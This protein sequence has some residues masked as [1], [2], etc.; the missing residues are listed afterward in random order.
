MSF[1]AGKLAVV[2]GANSGIGFQ[3]VRELAGEASEVIMICR[4]RERGEQA[5][6]QILKEYP[7]AVLTLLIA[8]LSSP[9]SIS[10]LMQEMRKRYDRISLLVNNAGGIFYNRLT[11]EDGLEYTFALNHMGYFRTTAALLP[12]LE[13]GRPSRVINV[14]SEAHR[15]TPL[16]FDDL[17]QEKHY[18]PFIA[19]GQSKLANILYTREL[20]RRYAKQGITAAALHPGFI[21]SGFGADAGSRIGAR[22]FSVTS[23]LFGSPPSRGAASVLCL[24]RGKSLSSGSYYAKCFIRKPSRAALDREAAERLWDLSTSLCGIT[25]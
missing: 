24:A 16:D 6:E 13:K 17:Q 21:N 20:A 9:S 12:L 11:A 3:T 4:S 1:I 7:Q 5:R 25:S 15:V 10:V 23:Q 18:R 19:Y 14:S 2:T 22:L 8:D